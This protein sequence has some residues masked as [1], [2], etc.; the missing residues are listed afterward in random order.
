MRLVCCISML[1][2]GM[3]VAAQRPKTYTVPAGVEVT[4]IVPQSEIFQYSKFT[5]G[6]VVFRDGTS[7]PGNLN[8]NRLVAELQFIAPKGDTLSLANEKN[9]LIAFV[10]TDTFYYNEG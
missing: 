9:I 5:P 10:G 1:L 7:A 2:L 8:Y 6:L 3:A 4:D